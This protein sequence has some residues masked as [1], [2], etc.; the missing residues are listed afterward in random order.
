MSVSLESSDPV[1]NTIRIYNWNWSKTRQ[2]T[3]LVQVQF[4]IS[5]Q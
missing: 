4:F 2:K 1:E 5:V 3:L